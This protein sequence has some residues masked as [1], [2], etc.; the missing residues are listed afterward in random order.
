M[1][2]VGVCFL[3]FLPVVLSVRGEGALVTLF[4]GTV[5]FMFVASTTSKEYLARGTDCFRNAV[6]WGFR[7]MA[8]GAVLGL[9]VKMLIG[10]W[11][12]DVPIAAFFGSVIGTTAGSV[13]GAVNSWIQL[14][15]DGRS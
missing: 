5:V 15:K 4:L 7:Y 10:G 14:R 1:V 11:I 6:A 13:G 3:V 9:L 8:I 12:S 2:G